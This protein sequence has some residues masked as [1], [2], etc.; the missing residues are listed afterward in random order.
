MAYESLH[1][2]RTSVRL[3]VV[4]LAWR[5][6]CSTMI[7]RAYSDMM[8]QLRNHS[9]Q[10]PLFQVMECRNMASSFCERLYHCIICCYSLIYCECSKNTGIPYAQAP[11]DDAACMRGDA[12]ATNL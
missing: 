3:V 8:K 5:K 12:V 6:A 10:L 11:P 9:S 7:Q 2:F 4:Q 1:L